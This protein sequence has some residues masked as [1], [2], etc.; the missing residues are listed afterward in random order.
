MLARNTAALGLRYPGV[1]VAGQYTGSLDNN[2]EPVALAHGKDAVFFEV[3]YNDSGRWPGRADGK[4]AALVLTDPA[5]IL[6][7]GSVE[8]S[9]F[10]NRGENWH[11]SIRYGGTPGEDFEEPP[12]EDFQSKY[13]D[14]GT[15]AIG[16]R[17]AEGLKSREE[18][19]VESA[20]EAETEA[21]PA[22]ETESA[23]EPETETE[24]VAEAESKEEG[25]A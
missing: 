25:D 9:E 1:T 4:G 13:A 12:P 20:P 10:L 5:A 15:A 18:A 7:M 17:I 3:D 19:P 6:T 24:A 16:E 23:K 2:G 21:E 22:T 14:S 11:S 8:Q